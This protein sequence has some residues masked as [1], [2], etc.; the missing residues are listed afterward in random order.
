MQTEDVLVGELKAGD[1]VINV[2]TQ[3]P[4]TVES[5]EMTSPG[6]YTVEDSGG[7]CGEIDCDC[8]VER[9]IED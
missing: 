9:V 4:V 5:I 2:D 7:Y 6:W 3:E 8:V 1:R